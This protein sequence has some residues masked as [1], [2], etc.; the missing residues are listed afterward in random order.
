MADC[1][2]STLVDIVQIQNCNLHNLPEN[3]SMRFYLFHYLVNP[4]TTRCAVLPGTNKICGYVMSKI[5]EQVQNKKEDPHGNVTSVS[6][7]RTHRKMGLAT[8]LMKSVLRSLAEIYD[9]PY[10]TLHVRK[11]NEAAKHLYHC[12]LGYEV[13][14]VVRSYFADGEDAYYMKVPTKREQFKHV[15][16][17]I[18]Q[19]REVFR[20]KKAAEKELEKEKQGDG[21]GGLLSAAKR[22][23]KK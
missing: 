13:D 12:T 20:Q 2:Q 3:Y 11:S 19:L 16:P 21:K 14:E 7:L 22:R 10:C 8:T 6:V 1:R 15:C 9:S 23:K 18:E 17:E 5:E 4:E